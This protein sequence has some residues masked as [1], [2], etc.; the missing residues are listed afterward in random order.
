MLRIMRYLKAGELLAAAVCLGLIVAQVWLDLKLPGYMYEVTTLVQ[1]PGS[2]MGEIWAN[3]GYMLLCALGSLASSVMVGFVVAMIGSS[4]AR[5]VRSM[6]FAKVESFSLEEMG[7]FST[8]SLI[9]RST[10]DVTQVQMFI[11]MG[12]QMMVKAP[13]TAVWAVTKIAGKGFEWTLVT[14]VGVLLVLAMV[15]LLMVFVIPK[16]RM[17]QTLTDNITRVARENLT[18]LR[19]VRAYN[20]E[21]Y[22]GAKFEA[23]NAE[24]TDTHLYTNRAMAIMM[25]FMTLIMSGLSIAIYWVGAYLV[26]A[27]GMAPN[28]AGTPERLAVFSN[29]VVFSNYAIQVI[30]SFMMIS[31]VFVMLPRA[32]VAARRINEVLGTEPSIVGGGAETGLAGSEGEVEFR[33]VSFRYPESADYA[34][35]NVSFKVRKGETAAIIGSTGSGKTTLVSLIPRFRDAT[36]GTVLVGGVDVRE[37]RHE[38]LLNA[39]GYVPQR[40]VLFT[41]T[42]GSNV[43][44]GDNGR[45]AFSA[46]A[47]A[48]ASETAQCAE[49]VMRM[50]GGLDAAIAQGGTNVSG[51]Q[52]QRISIARAVCREPEVLVFDD[53]FSALDFRTD[54]EL[55]GALRE[56]LPGTTRI[57]VAQ[58]I[59]TIMDSD[60]IVVLEEGRVVGIGRHG[61]LLRDCLV[62]REIAESQ[63]SEGELAS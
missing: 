25:P 26:D 20:A 58:R 40:S 3:G 29:M 5:R 39:I 33:D 53:S 8:P 11:V 48:A 45:G 34:L 18:G 1:T 43:G 16:F 62:Y 60:V 63:L 17:M 52:K 55:R 30:M 35:E 22:Q 36:E 47:I 61:D 14:G 13:I 59:G 37:Y 19:V 42:V 2:T 15:S 12:M 24:L 44:Y 32:G 9:T 27:A 23:A 51:G 50:D 54:K 31:I 21:G 56:K 7:R 38:S 6:L 10:N 28:A 46:E 4:F 57:V 49:F 41:G